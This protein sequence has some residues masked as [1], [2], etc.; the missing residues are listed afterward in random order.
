MVGAGAADAG[1]AASEIGGEGT[2][3]GPAEAAGGEPGGTGDGAPGLRLGNRL[4]EGDG[5][6]HLTVRFLAV[7]IGDVGGDVRLAI[8]TRRED[9]IVALIHGVVIL[10]LHLIGH[11]LHIVL[12]L[13]VH[14]RQVGDGVG[15]GQHIAHPQ[16]LGIIAGVHVQQI[17]H[18]HIIQIGNVVVAV[19]GL[20]SISDLAGLGGVKDLGNVAQ[21]HHQRGVGVF[22]LDLHVLHEVGVNGV[23]GDIAFLQLLQHFLQCVG[24]GGGGHRLAV[25]I[26]HIGVFHQ[27][28]LVG[29]VVSKLLAALHRLPGHHTDGGVQLVPVDGVVLIAQRLAGDVLDVAD[30]GVNGADTGHGAQLTA[31]IYGGGANGIQRQQGAKSD[32]HQRA[33]EEGYRVPLDLVQPLLESVGRVD[34]LSA[35]QREAVPQ[36]RGHTGDTAGGIQEKLGKSGF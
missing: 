8:Y 3:A 36:G 16:Q 17:V 25:N 12:P 31:V 10:I 32:H 21:I 33:A 23:G 19:A 24:E 2:A 7:D 13:H 14:H 27:T 6:H 11:V 29:K 18:G 9:F 4:A 34:L 20:H 22:L 35:A 1:V 5:G 30:H 28:Q 15:D 26:Q